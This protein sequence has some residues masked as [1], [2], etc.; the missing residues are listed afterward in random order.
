MNVVGK[1]RGKGWEAEL[2]EDG[3]WHSS[4]GP[5]QELLNMACPT[6]D[7]VVGFPLRNQLMEGA[8]LTSSEIVL[9]KIEQ[10]DPDK[11]Y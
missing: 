6:E 10:A 3:A 2:D 4:E 9:D 11:V 8:R 5:M 1:I 7:T